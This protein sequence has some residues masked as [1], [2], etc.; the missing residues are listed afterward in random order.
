MLPARL[1]AWLSSHH[2][3]LWARV[4][5]G[6]MTDGTRLSRLPHDAY[7]GRLAHEPLR[8]YV[9]DAFFTDHAWSAAQF[10]E[11]GTCAFR[12]FSKRLLA[13]APF[14]E[15]K[16]GMDQLILGSLCHA[17]LE[18]TYAHLRGR[19]LAEVSEDEAEAALETACAQVLPT[20]P[21]AYGFEPSPL[22]PSEQRAIRAR[23]AALL[24]H[25]RQYGGQRQVYALEQSFDMPLPLDG[26]S[27]TVRGVIDRIDVDGVAEAPT[28]LIID[29]K[30]GQPP[31]SRDAESGRNYQLL[32]Y[33]LAAEHMLETP[34]VS[35][36]FVPLRRGEIKPVLHAALNDP[37]M[38]Q[39]MLKR[40]ERTLDAMQAGNFAARANGLEEGKCYRH[41]DYAQFCRMAVTE[42]RKPRD[43]AVH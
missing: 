27:I 33:W 11:M 30:T 6:H 38:R 1:R 10:G 32:I 5:H 9:R 7:A 2:A 3:D 18:H 34:H 39:P 17:V 23:A 14:E 31:T 20:A 12:F 25:D 8:S 43:G 35:A 21:Q 28:Y 16:L 42:R 36:Q 26:R 24:A 4:L 19:P 40:L 22:W 29:Y 13:L 15:P 37:A 41:C